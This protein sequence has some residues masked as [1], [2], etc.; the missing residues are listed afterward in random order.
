MVMHEE[1]LE[2]NFRSI[3]ILRE[4]N[5]NQAAQPHVAK[6]NDSMIFWKWS[7]NGAVLQLYS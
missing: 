5:L 1:C 7:L 6:V 2:G 4:A 3:E